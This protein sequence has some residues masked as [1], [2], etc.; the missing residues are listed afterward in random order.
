MKI[1]VDSDDDLSIEDNVIII[2]SHI[3]IKMKI[4]TTV[5]YS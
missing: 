1:E 3:L 4:A 5:L 2:L